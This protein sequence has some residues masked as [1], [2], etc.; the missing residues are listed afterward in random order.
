[1]RTIAVLI[2]F[3]IILS[4]CACTSTQYVPLDFSDKK[5]PKIEI[6]LSEIQN[7]VKEYEVISYVE[8]S[9]AVFTTKKQLLRGLKKEAEKLRGNAVIDVKFFYIPW[10]L[11]SLPAVEGVVIKYK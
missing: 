2:T 10:V 4:I 1:M 11:S 7:P 3:C 6:F 8:T 9:G 5:S